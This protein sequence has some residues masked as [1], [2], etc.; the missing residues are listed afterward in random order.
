[1]GNH[2]SQMS[3]ITADE[4]KEYLKD[5]NKF[6]KDGSGSLEKPEIFKALEELLGHTPDE[7]AFEDFMEEADTDQNGQIDFNEFMCVVLSDSEWTADGQEYGAKKKKNQ[8]ESEE[9]DDTGGVKN[10]WGED[11]A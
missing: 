6:D 5:F 3:D 2:R 8:S 9:E 10:R 11:E 1:M 4:L 7:E